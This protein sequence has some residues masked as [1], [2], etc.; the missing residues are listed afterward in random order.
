MCQ[1]LDQGRS[2]VHPFFPSTVEKLELTLVRIMN[3]V[4]GHVSDDFASELGLSAQLV[5]KASTHSPQAI[6]VI[7]GLFGGTK[8][9]VFVDNRITRLPDKNKDYQMRSKWK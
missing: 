3:A 2:L 5:L 6:N 9:N 4:Y 8:T 7:G 1:V